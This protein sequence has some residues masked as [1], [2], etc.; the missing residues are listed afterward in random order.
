MAG[1][2]LQ[3]ISKDEIERARFRSRHMFRMDMEHNLIA[4]RDEGE[5][6][7]AM[8]IANNLLKRNRPID[9]IIEDTGLTREE[10]E[11]LRDAD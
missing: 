2:L 7:K 1:E 5:V 6:S 3:T 8:T 9:E 11:N 10:V 4:A